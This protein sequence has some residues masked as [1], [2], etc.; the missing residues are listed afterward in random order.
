MSS[1]LNSVTNAAS[2][3]SGLT[4][5]GAR[6]RQDPTETIA[7]VF[8][9]LDTEG[10][11]YLEAA[12]FE[13]AF[14]KLG[15]GDTGTSDE[16]LTLVDADRVI[17]ALDQDGDGK[18]TT[19]DLSQGLRAITDSVGFLQ[20]RLGTEGLE[21]MGA[22]PPPP[23]PPPGEQAGFTEEELTSQLAAL[24]ESDEASETDAYGSDLLANILAQFDTADAD[25]DGR[26]SGVEAMSFAQ[27]LGDADP[28]SNEEGEADGT[29]TS[30]A[31]SQGANADRATADL[32]VMRR[33]M[34]LMD[35]YDSPYQTSD[36]GESLSV[37]A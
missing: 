13:T 12:D 7:R 27:T 4:G 24:T 33:I 9:N 18:V 28:G 3:V 32:L 25:G 11:G 35:A 36:T 15:V 5:T 16:N 23:P 20:G 8:S 34:Q 10:K 30:T 6:Q 17:S 14:E 21:A 2:M 31:G 19:E 26:I 37:S 29:T 22:M 1:L